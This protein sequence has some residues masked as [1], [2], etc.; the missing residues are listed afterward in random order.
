[1]RAQKDA[2]HPP[3]GLLNVGDH[4]GMNVIHI[5]AQ[6]KTAVDGRLIGD[7]DDGGGD[8]GQRAHPI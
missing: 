6:R 5:F 4:A 8:E 1:M 7:N 3:A 2:I